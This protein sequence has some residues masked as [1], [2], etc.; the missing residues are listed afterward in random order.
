M[1][2]T[3]LEEIETLSSDSL[4]LLRHLEPEP[5]Y[6]KKYIETECKKIEQKGWIE[7]ESDKPW[8]RTFERDNYRKGKFFHATYSSQNSYVNTRSGLDDDSWAR[9][10]VLS[11]YD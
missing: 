4:M 1:A 11:W 3:F 10:R 8:V 5:N 2:M 9:V 6:V 7:Q